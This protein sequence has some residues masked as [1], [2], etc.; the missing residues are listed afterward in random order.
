MEDMTH[1]MV[2]CR[3]E[4]QKQCLYKCKINKVEFELNFASD[5]IKE[6]REELKELREDDAEDTEEGLLVLL[7]DELKK[8][9]SSKKDLFQK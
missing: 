5:R 1:I 6:I 4:L 7:K 3:K 9:K 8:T 2:N